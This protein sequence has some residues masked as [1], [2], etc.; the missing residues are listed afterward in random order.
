[1]TAGVTIVGA[2][3]VVGLAEEVGVIATPLQSTSIAAQDIFV[4]V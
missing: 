4:S 3:V 1:M 2:T